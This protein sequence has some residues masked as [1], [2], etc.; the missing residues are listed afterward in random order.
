MIFLTGRDVTLLFG[1]FSTF[2]IFFYTSNVRVNMISPQY[3]K[4]LETFAEIVQRG[5]R[6][7]I[8]TDLLP[9]RL[10][11]EK[12]ILKFIK[13]LSY[14]VD[15]HLLLLYSLQTNLQMFHDK[16]LC[17]IKMQRINLTPFSTPFSCFSKK[18]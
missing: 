14:L 15:F 8:P 7:Y 1:I 9:T 6:V 10:D 12:N 13:K 5:A 18:K 4:S 3:E 11:I 16:A 17:Y 2:M